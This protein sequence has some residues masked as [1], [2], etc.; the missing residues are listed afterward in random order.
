M[1]KKQS[2]QRYDAKGLACPPEEAGL[3]RK[4]SNMILNNKIAFAFILII[5]LFIVGQIIVPG[6]STF[7][8]IMSVL[9][10]SFFL[11][12]VGLGQTLVVISGREGID[13]SV[14]ANVTMGVVMG[15]ALINGVD[16]N[17]PHAIALILIAGFIMGLVNGIGVS[18][19]RIAPLIMTM[20]WGIVI[21]GL[22]LFVIKGHMFGTGSPA[23][24]AL[25]HGALNIGRFKIPSVV[26]IWIVI[27]I[28]IHFVMT[29][30]RGGRSLYA[31]GENDRAAELMGLKVKR[32]RAVVY[33]ISGALSAVTGVLLLGFVGSAHLNLGA[34]YVLPS[35]VAVIIGGI[36][37]GGGA[38]NY[39][40]TVAGAI[41]LT[42]LQSI[43]V[44]LEL[45][46]G[47]RQLIT[48]AV[49]IALLLAYTRRQTR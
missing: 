43:L 30:T 36:R 8:H 10:A 48:G 20:A 3:G 41:F 29:R 17:L 12:L 22:L 40:G 47:G 18:Y 35:A 9:Q 45:S 11:G 23:L 37:F 2:I 16:A 38:G 26:L 7:N 32:F 1:K 19:L 33:G 24:E 4:I 21:E 14:G 13:L 46:Q 25:G 44:T 34:R 15:A 42:S 49:L 6:F 31:M 27:T 28:V 39:L 5:L